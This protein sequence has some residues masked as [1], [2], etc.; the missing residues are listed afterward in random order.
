LSHCDR[1]E[2]NINV[3]SIIA[4]YR[5]ETEGGVH[6]AR[7]ADVTPLRRLEKTMSDT[8]VTLDKIKS[9]T[10]A[11]TVRSG[12]K[13]DRGTGD[14]DTNLSFPPH[15]CVWLLIVCLG[16]SPL[17]CVVKQIQGMCASGGSVTVFLRAVLHGSPHDQ[18]RG[19]RRREAVYQATIN[20]LNSNTL[21]DKNASDAIT[22]LLDAAGTLRSGCL[23]RF[24]KMCLLPVAQ[25]D[26]SSKMGVVML[27][28][29]CSVLVCS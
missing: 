21:V 10:I 27:L 8:T 1:M 17:Y 14:F 22:T 3:D 25:P 24:V 29:G 28:Y 15:L 13:C 18:R 20:A 19:A 9:D 11:K 2:T 26:R 7:S 5:R 23:P 12:E 6:V 4:M 16:I